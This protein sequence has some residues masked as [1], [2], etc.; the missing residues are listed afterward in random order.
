MSLSA[1]RK[2]VR[3]HPGNFF[4]T[5]KRWHRKQGFASCTGFASGLLTA[6]YLY[7]ANYL[8]FCENAHSVLA[9]W[10]N[11]MQG[12]KAGL[13]CQA[14]LVLKGLVAYGFC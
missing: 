7:Q 11:W 5:W 6:N 3:Q 4:C 10:I 8:A 13:F 12:K 1:V 9:S 2:S 14:V